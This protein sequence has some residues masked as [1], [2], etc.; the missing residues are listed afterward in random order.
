MQGALPNGFGE[1]VMPSIYMIFK[2]LSNIHNQY[3]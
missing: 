3:F 1:I 2:A